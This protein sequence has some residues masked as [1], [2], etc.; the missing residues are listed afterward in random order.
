MASRIN[1]TPLAPMPVPSQAMRTGAVNNLP[2]NIFSGLGNLLQVASNYG[3]AT[4]DTNT[5]AAIANVLA[6]DDINSL[7]AMRSGLLDAPNAAGTD[8][9]KVSAAIAGQSQLLNKEL[10]QQNAQDQY[11]IKEATR[12]YFS[13]P[14]NAGAIQT[15]MSTG[16]LP[17]NLPADPSLLFELAKGGYAVDHNSKTLLETS[18][19]NRAMERQ[20]DRRINNDERQLD[21]TE[22]NSRY[23]RPDVVEEY[24]DP[25][26]KELVRVQSN[27]YSLGNSTL[28]TGSN[29]AKNI[30]AK[31]VHDTVATMRKNGTAQILTEL[32]LDNDPLTLAMIAIESGGNP[33]ARSSS[34][35]GLG[36]IKTTDASYY[37]KR[38][39]IKGNVNEPKVNMQITA[40][41]LKHLNNKFKGNS[42]AIAI[43]YNGGEHAAD[44]AYKKWQESGQQGQVRDYIPSTYMAKGKQR[45]YDTKQ[46]YNHAVKLSQA[47]DE[48]NNASGGSARAGGGSKGSPV[49]AK[50]NLIPVNRGALQAATT[51]YN[52]TGKSNNFKAPKSS[53]EA[54]VETEA[55][56]A[57]VASIQREGRGK[58]GNTPKETALKAVQNW[59]V[60]RKAD[61]GTKLSLLKK[62]E[63]AQTSVGNDMHKIRKEVERVRTADT[64]AER[65]KAQEKQRATFK[66][67]AEKYNK[68]SK[69]KLSEEQIANLIDPDAYKKLF[70]N[71]EVGKGVLLRSAWPR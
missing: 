32:G 27:T 38:Y 69:V 28:G 31:A 6:E 33:N 39:G 35:A 45:K 13:D 50:S 54:K 1:Y 44:V 48:I 2:A 21:I 47:L 55:L 71:D 12:Q 16:A 65:K 40:A 18:Q 43:A 8:L 5:N 61:D 60:Y 53:D 36:Q 37:A 30:G 24:I 49:P 23:D 66:K 10:E 42:D 58:W 46:M 4:R 15:A 67:V 14:T 9:K 26:T 19:H 17:E 34:S 64:V 11:N 62:A 20:G 25:E 51:L 29:R 52:E 59:D 68:T 7:A 57:H 56:D 22:A 3:N 63:E 70:R 41:H